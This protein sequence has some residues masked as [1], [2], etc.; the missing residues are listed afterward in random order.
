MNDLI[1]TQYFKEYRKELGFSR[2]D[3]VKIFL[4]PKI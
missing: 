1:N 3:D 4:V 2:Q